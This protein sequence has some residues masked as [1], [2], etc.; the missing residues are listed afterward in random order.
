MYGQL[1]IRWTTLKTIFRDGKG[2]LQASFS[3]KGLHLVSLSD[4]QSNWRS[5]RAQHETIIPLG[6][7][8]QKTPLIIE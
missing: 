1:I 7:E 3:N 4:R 6:N 5:E 8:K 2:N